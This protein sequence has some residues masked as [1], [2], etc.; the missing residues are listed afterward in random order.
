MTNKTLT[1]LFKYFLIAGANVLMSRFTLFEV[2]NETKHDSVT[3]T[4]QPSAVNHK[5]EIRYKAGTS[6]ELNASIY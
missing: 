1:R 5:Y 3:V 4:I 6:L 2:L